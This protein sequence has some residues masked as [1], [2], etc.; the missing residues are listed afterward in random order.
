MR[1]QAHKH[2]ATVS[3]GLKPSSRSPLSLFLCFLLSIWLEFPVVAACMFLLTSPAQARVSAEHQHSCLNIEA[4][5][6][7]FLETHRGRGELPLLRGIMPLVGWPTG[8]VRLAY[9]RKDRGVGY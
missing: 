6:L 9:L 4:G 7:H 1:T 3:D 2:T 8:P 5:D